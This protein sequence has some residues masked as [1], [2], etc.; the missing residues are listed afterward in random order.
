MKVASVGE[1]KNNLSKI[2]SIAEH[3][4]IVQILRRNV[5]IARLV[6]Y[7]EIKEKKNKTILG[8]GHG[9]VQVKGNLTEPMIPE[10]NWDML[11]E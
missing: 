2:L 8:C 5:P 1:L 3:G 10:N 6:P 11:K 4:E 9:T 7:Y